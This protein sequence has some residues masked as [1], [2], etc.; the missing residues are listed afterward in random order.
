MLLVAV[1]VVLGL[2]FILS[3]L[4]I[5]VTAGPIMKANPEGY[6]VVNLPD[7]WW[8]RYKGL[9]FLAAGLILNSLG[10]LMSLALP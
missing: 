2:A 7:T 5:A 3:V 1:I 10:S 4:G 6:V 8:G 9:T